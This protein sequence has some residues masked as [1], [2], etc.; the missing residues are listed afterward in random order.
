M[1]GRSERGRLVTDFKVAQEMSPWTTQTDEDLA[2]TDATSVITA[3]RED[4]A[5]D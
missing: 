1:I 3:I 4:A 2:A 5:G